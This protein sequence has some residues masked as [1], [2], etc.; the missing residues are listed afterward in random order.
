MTESLMFFTFMH[1]DPP[2]SYH[3]TGPPPEV[4]IF[5]C[6]GD[7]HRP[8]YKHGLKA[9]PK[10]TIAAKRYHT[11]HEIF[12]AGWVVV[13]DPAHLPPDQKS[14]WLC[15]RCAQIQGNRYHSYHVRRKPKEQPQWQT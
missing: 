10:D 9:L 1:I 8:T 6:A 14:F 15:P 12:A 4:K 7:A 11:V 13:T 5:R 3:I 2:K